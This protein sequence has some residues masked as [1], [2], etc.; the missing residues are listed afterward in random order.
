MRRG[1][2][3]DLSLGMTLSQKRISAVCE[4]DRTRVECV[5]GVKVWLDEEP[6]GEVEGLGSER[7]PAMLLQTPARTPALLAR[8]G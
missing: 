4:A 6:C 5:R 1:I 7:S 3:G 8:R 2:T